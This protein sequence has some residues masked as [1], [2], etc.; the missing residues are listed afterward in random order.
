MDLEPQ[1]FSKKKKIQCS[2]VIFLC[3]A[4]TERLKSYSPIQKVS[5]AGLEVK[6]TYLDI[7]Y[8]I[9]HLFNTS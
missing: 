3:S 6:A 1:L 5:K 7:Q 2:C 9:Q 8:I 4:H